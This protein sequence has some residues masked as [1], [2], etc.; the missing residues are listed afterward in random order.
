MKDGFPDDTTISADEAL[1]KK[2]KLKKN[3][4]AELRLKDGRKTPQGYEGLRG[5]IAQYNNFTEDKTKTPRS[6]EEAVENWNASL[7][8]DE[9]EVPTDS[10]LYACF[11]NLRNPLRVDAKGEKF[12]NMGDKARKA[13]GS[14]HD[15]LIVDDVRDPGAYPAQIENG[16]SI[17]VFSP[18]QIKSAT[19]NRGTFDSRSANITFSLATGRPLGKVSPR[20]AYMQNMIKAVE[21]AGDSWQ[22]LFANTE[23]SAKSP[24]FGR[25]AA[26][27]MGSIMG[28]AMKVYHELPRSKRKV[29]TDKL[30]RAAVYAR[31]VED[32]KILTYGQVPSE[33]RARLSDAVADELAEMWS[34]QLGAAGADIEVSEET[35][36]GSKGAVARGNLSKAEV[37]QLWRETAAEAARNV[38]AAEIGKV[39]TELAEEAAAQMK[40][41]LHEDAMKDIDRILERFT[42]K[43]DKKSGKLK[44]GIAHAD[45][46]HEVEE[47]GKLI[48][49]SAKERDDTIQELMAKIDAL[50]QNEDGALSVEDNERRE[51][52]EAEL[53]DWTLFGAARHR[54]W[55]AAMAAR[56]RLLNRA[57]LGI[58][59]WRAQEAYRKAQTD[60]LVARTLRAIGGPDE[61]KLAAQKGNATATNLTGAWKGLELSNTTLMALGQLFQRMSTVPGIGE[62]CAETVDMISDANLAALRRKADLEA[63]MRSFMENEL[64]H[65]TERERA[66]FMAK[67]QQLEQ[68]N[69]KPKGEEK[70]FN[71]RISRA[72]AGEWLDMSPEAREAYRLEWEGAKNPT[73]N[74]KPIPDYALDA[75]YEA[76]NANLAGKDKDF[77]T[78]DVTGR[79]GGNK[80]PLCISRNQALNVLLLC[81]QE[82]YRANAD[83]HGYTAEVL[84]QLRE[85]CGEDVLKLGIWMRTW[86]DNTGL[87]QVYEA[88]E[89]VPFP[90]EENYWPGNFDLSSKAGEEKNNVPGMAQGSAI[91]GG[92]HNMLKTRVTHNLAFDLNLGAT[93]AF[94]ANVAQTDNYI[95]Y[96]EITR[97]WRALLSHDAFARG[98]RQ[99]IG[100]AEFKAL[101]EGLNMLDMQGIQEALGQQALSKLMARVQS[102]AAPML[103]A[104]NVGTMA[105]Q[106]T[107]LLHA[108]AAPGFGPFEL[109]AEMLHLRSGKGRMT[110][111]E[112]AQQPIFRARAASRDTET[113]Q[114]MMSAGADVK[115][116]GL[117]ALSQYGMDKLEALDGW[118]NAVSMT[119]LYNIQWRRLEKDAKEAGIALDEGYAHAECMKIVNRTMDQAAQPKLQTQKAMIQACGGAGLFGRMAFYMG[120]EQLNKIGLIIRNFSLNNGITEGFHRKMKL[121]QRRAY[122]FRNFQNYRLR[123]LVECSGAGDGDSKSGFHT[124][125]A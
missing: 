25:M 125:C 46:Y 31:M 9:V 96:G 37:Q 57:V 88:R 73:P 69:I 75:L 53:D 119:A 74:Q 33:E 112:M 106:I 43:K 22:A 117:D 32:G 11:L 59:A 1:T 97:K 40:V 91:G 34:D 78:V 76:Y 55:E 68:T 45:T 114:R 116:S 90:A 100:E 94:L 66:E 17:A 121:I 6:L 24:G 115:Y 13:K 104:F 29:M 56:D 122:G 82:R 54:G 64:G 14:G 120:S 39:Y 87:K 3:C 108:T 7:Q 99:H 42:P 86:L 85:F 71:E 103:L 102:V 77:I 47:L 113:W 105:K 79:V 41:M 5:M 60:A 4:R 10:K 35:E 83:K 18:A 118:A 98:L 51:K 49:K 95:C 107:A 2:G 8:F 70:R 36:R 15:G 89:G 123:V 93:Q 30:R 81:G 80:A 92:K 26:Q 44:R 63:A 20:V 21:S 72:W 109:M 19:D 23:Y 61:G 124:L 52:L 65:K 110:V 28:L 101:K 38:G 67:L 111:D 12:S 48:N 58:E 84:D 27:Q 16:A 62:F 50:K